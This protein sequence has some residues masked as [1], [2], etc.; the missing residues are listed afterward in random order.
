MWNTQ[1]HPFLFPVAYSIFEYPAGIN[2]F[3]YRFLSLYVPCFLNL[4]LLS[5]LCMYQGALIGIL[6]VAQFL[7]LILLIDFKNIH[8]NHGLY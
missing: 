7:N 6:V 3:L 2:L 5:L 8:S 4:Y 1:G